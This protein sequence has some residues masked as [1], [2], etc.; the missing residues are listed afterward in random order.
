[1]PGTSPSSTRR[2][3]HAVELVVVHGRVRARDVVGAALRT[4][5]ERFWRVAGTAFV[6][7]GIVAAVDALA[8][9]LV[10]DRHVSRPFGAALTSVLAGVFAMAG[11]VIYAGI[12]DKVV[13]AHLHGHADIPVHKIP[14]V[15]PLRRLV[16]ADIVLSFATVVGLALLVVPGIV[17]FTMWSLVGPIITI[18]ERAVF[19]ALRRS[20]SLVRPSFWLTFFLVTIPLQIEQAVLHAIHYTEIFEHPLIPALCLNGLLGMV[21]GSIV[22]LIE[23][24]LAYELIKRAD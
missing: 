14:T 19:S 12:L 13:G 24:V 1:M 10:I 7:F 4:Y 6:V 8:T 3:G 22:G 23:V 18:E 5:R 21:V 9:V 20:W 2:S 17:V 16:V 11:V 15:L